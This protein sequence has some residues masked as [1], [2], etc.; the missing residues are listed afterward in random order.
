MK[1]H[2]RVRAQDPNAPAI[3]TPDVAGS[4][5]PTPDMAGSA[6]IPV[7]MEPPRMPAAIK[8]NKKKV[9]VRKELAK[10]RFGVI[11][12][13]KRYRQRVALDIERLNVKALLEQAKAD[14]AR[15][16]SSRSF[17]SEQAEDKSERTRSSAQL[18]LNACEKSHKYF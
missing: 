13:S 6:K 5:I 10:K 8:K 18:C 15:S 9:V 12:A 2:L 14:D 16:S 4:A 7:R 17:D 1:L 11:A 3:P